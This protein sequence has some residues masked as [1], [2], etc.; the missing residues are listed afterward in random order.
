MLV[1]KWFQ[2]RKEKADLKRRKVERAEAEKLEDSRDK[3]E[4]ERKKSTKVDSNCIAMLHKTFVCQ[5][6]FVL[7]QE[8][9]M[10]KRKKAEY[11]KIQQA[12]T[13]DVQV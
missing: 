7:L 8:V 4:E 9:K 11:R 2:Q 10:A 12:V 6:I 1:I 3:K 5:Q 13:P